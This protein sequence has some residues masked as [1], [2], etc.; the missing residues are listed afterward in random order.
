MQNIKQSQCPDCGD[1]AASYLIGTRRIFRQYCDDCR[2][3]REQEERDRRISEQAEAEQRRL[4]AM[5]RMHDEEITRR[6]DAVIPKKFAG[7]EVEHLPGGLV[8]KFK[9]LPNGQGLFLFGPAGCGKTYAMAAF[10]KMYIRA[11]IWQVKIMNWERFLCGLRAS[12]GNEP[13]RA[14]RTIQEAM[15]AAILFIDDA[16]LTGGQESDFSLR[17]MYSI[18]DHRVEWCLPTFFAANRQPDDLAAAYDERIKSRVLG[19]CEIVHL[20]GKDK[21]VR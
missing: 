21:R 18:I 13:G 2:R 7:A 1:V 5:Q 12:Y 9:S 6:I 10:A 4:A 14:D 16:M 11:D 15:E 8:D 20:Q 17:T 3:R 19:C